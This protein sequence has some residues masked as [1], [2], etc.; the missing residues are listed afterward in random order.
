MTRLT[1]ILSIQR[2]PAFG[3][4]DIVE[5]VADIDQAILAILCIPKDGDPHR[6]DCGPIPNIHLDMPLDRAA[7]H[8]VRAA[9]RDRRRGDAS[10]PPFASRCIDRAL[11]ANAIGFITDDEA[12]TGK[13]L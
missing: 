9:M 11:R 8:R 2:Q 3:L 4:D 5:G 1:E 6:P 13:A 12:R 7:R 10:M